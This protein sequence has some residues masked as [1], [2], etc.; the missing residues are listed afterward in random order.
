MRS[1]AELWMS[2]LDKIPLSG[3]FKTKDKCHL[4]QSGGGVPRKG[5]TLYGNRPMK[6]PYTF[7]AKMVQFPY[8]FHYN[9]NWYF[10]YYSWAVIASLPVFFYLERLSKAPENVKKWEE[11]KRKEE[12][13][14]HEKW[15]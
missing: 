12:K 1:T 11:I 10:K 8:Q 3:L 2:M 5:F 4:P 13:E 15:D 9:T 6:F 14:L 7:T